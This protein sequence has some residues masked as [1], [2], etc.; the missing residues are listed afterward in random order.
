[1]QRNGKYVVHVMTFISQSKLYYLQLYDEDAKLEDPK[2]RISDDGGSIWCIE[3]DGNNNALGGEAG[4]IAILYEQAPTIPYE[5][6]AELDD[7]TV[8]Q[9]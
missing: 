4:N 6:K 5:I 9:A 1:M 2:D 7:G 3:V 8:V